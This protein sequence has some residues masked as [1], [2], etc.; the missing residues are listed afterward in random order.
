MDSA[1]K[2]TCAE[3]TGSGRVASEDSK[4]DVINA[5][6]SGE[7]AAPEKSFMAPPSLVYSPSR[8]FFAQALAWSR[9]F[10]FHPH[11]PGMCPDA[12]EISATQLVRRACRPDPESLRGRFPLATVTPFPT[13]CNRTQQQRGFRKRGG[14]C[15]PPR[16][17]SRIRIRGLP[18]FPAYAGPPQRF[19]RGPGRTHSRAIPDK[20][21]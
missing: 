13:E 7:N 5:I 6:V 20:P 17:S 1:S 14:H 12:A 21:L 8:H 18:R 4:T 9:A 10:E 11:L 19:R 3:L 15:C 16:I 2:L